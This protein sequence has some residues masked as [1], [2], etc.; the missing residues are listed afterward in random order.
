MQEKKQK[1]TI[2]ADK[3]ISL[4]GYLY[5]RY[6]YAVESLTPLSTKNYFGFWLYN[7]H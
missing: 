1:A 6:C 2:P 4:P 3:K 5:K 7:L